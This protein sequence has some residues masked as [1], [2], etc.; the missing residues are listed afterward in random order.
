MAVRVAP[1]LWIAFALVVSACGGRVIGAPSDG[2]SG[3]A[4]SG[5][6]TSSSSGRSSG[7]GTS[8]GGGTSS[9]SSNGDVGASSSGGGGFVSVLRANNDLCLPQPLKRGTDG[10]ALCAVIAVL[11]TPGPSSACVG[12]PG[13]SPAPDSVAAAVQNAEPGVF[14]GFPMCVVAQIP[15][16]GIA[17]GTCED[18]AEPGWCYVEGEA[19]KSSCEQAL[20]FSKSGEPPPG[21]SVWLACQ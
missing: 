6:A 19:T 9:G 13:L 18:V 14:V 20:R 11:S 5:S 7:S 21:A 16:A 1:C 12:V 2:T 17:S 10:E 15:V 3:A 4:S 8:S